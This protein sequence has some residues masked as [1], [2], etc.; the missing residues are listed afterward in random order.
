MK[1]KD[2]SKADVGVVIARMQVHELHKAHRE[3]VD[4]VKSVSD[5]LIIILG[6]PPTKNTFAGSP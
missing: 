6:I 4:Y 5:R 1:I 2:D 3:L